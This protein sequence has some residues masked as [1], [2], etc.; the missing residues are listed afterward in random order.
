MRGLA[1][2][3]LTTAFFR[4]LVKNTPDSEAE[5]DVPETDRDYDSLEEVPADAPRKRKFALQ[6]P[7]VGRRLYV[8]GLNGVISERA[9][10]GLHITHALVLA[11]ELRSVAIPD[12]VRVRRVGLRDAE[13]EDLLHWL[14]VLTEFIHDVIARGGRVVVCCVAGVS[15]SVS[16]C[17]AY[18]VAHEGLSLRQAWQELHQARAMASPNSGFWAQLIRWEEACRGQATVSLLPHIA[19]PTPDVPPYYEQQTRMAHHSWYMDDLVM[20]FSFHFFLLLSQVVGF[21]W[22][23]RG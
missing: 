17:L 23:E 10:R 1:N 3:D 18:K 21:F 16:V 4:D 11:T 20:F 6:L 15:R 7:R 2:H 8:C 12:C 19:G 14:P 9:L 5:S 22:P 13:D